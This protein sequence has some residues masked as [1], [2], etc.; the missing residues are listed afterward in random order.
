MN[1]RND[2]NSLS[3]A[4]RLNRIHNLRLMRNTTDELSA[5]TGIQLGNN[6]FSRKSPFI[7]RCIYS[8]FAREVAERTGFDLDDLLTNYESI[9]LL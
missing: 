4:E 8:E 7:T 6:S 5:H 1:T 3:F 9:G 2:I